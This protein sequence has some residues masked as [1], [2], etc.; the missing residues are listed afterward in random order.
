MVE[1][2]LKTADTISIPQVYTVIGTK[3]G[4]CKVSGRLKVIF[5]VQVRH[6]R[7]II[8]VD[9]NK[10]LFSRSLNESY[11]GLLLPN[12]HGFYYSISLN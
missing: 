6:L 12:P 1:I 10:V 7:S 8:P 9:V 5:F 2:A 11:T 4:I 3:V